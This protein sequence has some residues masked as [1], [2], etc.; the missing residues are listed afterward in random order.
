MNPELI[1]P[2]KGPMCDYD[3][4]LMPSAE[5]VEA[6]LKMQP[7]FRWWN[8]WFNKPKSIAEAG[9]EYLCE[10]GYSRFSGWDSFVWRNTRHEIS[11][12]IYIQFRRVFGRSLTLCD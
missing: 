11:L 1:K 7:D 8:R 4:Y 10:N 6:H 2:I 9:K 3:Y 12:S 5:A